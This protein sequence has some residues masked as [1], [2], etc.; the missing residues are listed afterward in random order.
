[1][2]EPEPS[3]IGTNATDKAPSHNDRLLVEFLE[4]NDAPCPVCGYNV[5]R[6]TRPVC[7]ECQHH[8]QLTVG[9]SDVSLRWFLAMIAPGVFSGIAAVFLAIPIIVSPLAGNGAAPGFIVATDAFGFV[10]GAAALIMMAR[11]RRLVAMHVAAQQRLM[12]AVWV[13][14]VLALLLVMGKG[15]GWY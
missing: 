10:S 15:L 13:V 2:N 14:H 4:S 9:A 6:L 3:S 1:M 5:R 8:L 11:R 7:P 12:A